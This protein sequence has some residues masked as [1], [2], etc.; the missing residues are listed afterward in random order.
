MLIVFKL[1]LLT[2]TM[3]NF[4]MAK[5]RYLLNQMTLLESAVSINTLLQCKGNIGLI[6]HTV[7]R[8]LGS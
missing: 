4:K 6:G 7:T 3:L 1:P 8:A 5:M 2:K